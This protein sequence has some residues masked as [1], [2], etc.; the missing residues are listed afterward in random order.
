MEVNPGFTEIPG[1][2][3]TFIVRKATRAKYVDAKNP[4]ELAL[5]CMEW[6]KE[7]SN[8]KQRSDTSCW[9]VEHG[10]TPKKEDTYQQLFNGELLF[11]PQSGESPLQR[12]ISELTTLFKGPLDLCWCGDGAKGLI[13]TTDPLV[14]FDREN[15]E[16]HLLVLITMRSLINKK[17]HSIATSFKP[18][19]DGWNEDRAPFGIFWRMG[20]WKNLSWCFSRTDVGPDDISS[21]NL[22][23]HWCNARQHADRADIPFFI[24]AIM[25]NFMFMLRAPAAKGCD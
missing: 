15:Y 7:I 1:E 2:L 6:E 18:L 14:F 12:T 17:L 19:M 21:K 3:R 22:Y 24:W 10:V 16:G 25:K 13:V 5:V 9:K 11:D 23:E 20:E 8:E 4:L